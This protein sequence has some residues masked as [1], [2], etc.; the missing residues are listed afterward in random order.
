MNVELEPIILMNGVGIPTLWVQIPEMRRNSLQPVH[1]LY[2]YRITFIY[3]TNLR[4]SCAFFSLPRGA[5]V[6]ELQNTLRLG[7]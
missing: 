6:R 1:F 7:P 3:L 4:T 2:R 5:I